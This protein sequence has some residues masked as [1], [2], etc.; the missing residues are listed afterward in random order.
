M[1]PFIR[2]LNELMVITQYRNQLQK[3]NDNKSLE[4]FTGVTL[5]SERNINTKSKKK[6]DLPVLPKNKS[7]RWVKSKE[8]VSKFFEELDYN[9]QIQSSYDLTLLDRQN[10]FENHEAA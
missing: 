4:E 10:N 2:S 1:I 3:S 7:R 6:I 8:A 5:Q 9:N